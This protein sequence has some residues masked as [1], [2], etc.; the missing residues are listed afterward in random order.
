MSALLIPFLALVGFIGALLWFF[1]ANVGVM[2]LAACS[3]LV[4]LSSID[5]VVITTAGSV[6]PSEGEAYVRLS[7][8][9]LSIVFASMMFRNAVQGTKF[10]L[11]GLIALL[12]SVVLLLVLPETTGVSW[13]VAATEQQEWQDLNEFRSLIL[14]SGFALSLIAVLTTQKKTHHKKSKH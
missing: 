12:L 10:L 7:V 11:H 9:L 3:G 6:V 14:A 4:L 8:V 13:L 5:P 2:F 1:K